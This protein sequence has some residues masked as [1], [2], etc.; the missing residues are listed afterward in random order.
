MI[1]KGTCAAVEEVGLKVPLVVRLA[2][3]GAES[4]KEVL[5]NSG[6]NL[7]PADDLD[8][9]CQSIMKAIK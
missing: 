3:N 5:R 6:L 1:A 8:E 9:A 4:G 2:G 7:I